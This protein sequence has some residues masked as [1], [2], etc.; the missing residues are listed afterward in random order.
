MAGEVKEYPLDGTVQERALYE[1]H[2]LFIGDEA[3]VPR[4]QR[5]QHFLNTIALKELG[6]HG[7]A[8][9]PS[10]FATAILPDYRAS[11]GGPDA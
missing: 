3:T 6:V 5:A 10:T 8:E 9:L 2:E 1:A 11:A 4:H 7:G